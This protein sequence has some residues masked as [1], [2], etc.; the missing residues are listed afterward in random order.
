[1]VSETFPGIT[2]ETTTAQSGVVRLA[3]DKA[4]M[5]EVSGVAYSDGKAL[6][7][8]VGQTVPNP[9]AAPVTPQVP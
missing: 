4:P 9:N 1:L 8:L 6:F 5:I 7:A 2:S 3:S